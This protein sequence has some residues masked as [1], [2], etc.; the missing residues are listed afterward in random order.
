M[1][2]AE[3]ILT[4]DLFDYELVDS[5]GGRKLERFG[6]TWLV[7]PEVR[8]TWQPTDSS[9]W[10]MSQAEF[11]EDKGWHRKTETQRLSW[12]M[13]FGAIT[14]ECETGSSKQ[15]GVFPENAL[16]WDWIGK[17]LATLPD[18]AEVL[19]LFGYTGIASLVA[20]QAGAIVTHI[21]SSRRALRTGQLNQKLSG[22]QDAKIRWLEEDALS[23]V[24]REAR[25]G[26]KYS[27]IILDPPVFGM[28]PKKQRW[29]LED[30][31]L[32]LCITCNRIL[33]PESSFLVATI[34]AYDRS[35]EHLAKYLCAAVPNCKK[36]E[37]GELILPESSTGR[38]LE[39]AVS[40]RWRAG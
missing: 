27:G 22:L 21:D 33:M 1:P 35:P 23:F 17:E 29:R 24:Q 3:H 18:G 7:R 16:Q 2:V 28:G 26:R 31:L 32:E 5:G 38:K 9:N 11:V 19:N 13:K 40:G 34:Y 14:M 25:R 6:S 36:L 15:V 8:A 39:M 10:L 12:N 30:D 37:M 20:A 4:K